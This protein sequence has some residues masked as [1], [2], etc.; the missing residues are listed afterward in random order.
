[1][2]EGLCNSWLD[3][4]GAKTS[5]KN[6]TLLTGLLYIEGINTLDKGKR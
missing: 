1:M 3:S 2:E 5:I 6:K 4:H